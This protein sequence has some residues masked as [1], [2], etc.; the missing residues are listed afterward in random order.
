M[1]PVID[2]EPDQT[3]SDRGGANTDVD[4]TD[5]EDSV[6]TPAQSRSPSV[7]PP[8]EDGPD[9]FDGY[10]FKGRHSVLIDDDEDPEEEDEEVAE[11]MIEELSAQKEQLQDTVHDLHATIE[12]LENLKELNDELEINH[13]EAEKQMQEEIDFKDSLLL[14]REKTAKLQQDALDDR[15]RRDGEAALLPGLSNISST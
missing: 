3:D 12:D 8:D 1:E 9:L 7:R 13:V 14:D 5:G 10:S 4:K 6:L 2:N 11:E 15:K